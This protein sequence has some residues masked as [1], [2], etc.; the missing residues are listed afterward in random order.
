MP[1]PDVSFERARLD[2]AQSCL[3]AMRAR[4]A[5]KVANDDILAANEADTEAVRWHLQRRLA[6][7]DDDAA[8]LCFGRIDEETGEVWYVGRRHI[9]DGDAT[10]VVVDWRAGVATPFYRATLADPFGLRGRRRFVFNGRDL[11]DVFEEDFTDPDSL[12]GSGGVPDPLL[13]E[14]GRARTGQMRDIV[15]TIQAEQD[16]IIRAPIETCLVVQGGP[17]TGKTAVGLHRAAFLM[18]EHRDRLVR[19]GVLV[20]GPNPVFLRYISQVLPSLGE[21]S[22]TQTTVD[23]LLSLRFRIVAEDP[24]AV[25]AVKGDARLAEVIAHGAADAIRIPDEGVTVRFRTR[26]FTLAPDDVRALVADARRR[27]APFATQR[28]RFRQ[29]LVRRA[30]DRYTGGVAIE[31]DEHDFGVALLA[32]AQSRKAIDGCWRSVSPVAL[33]R[34]LLTQRG[35]L[36]RAADGVLDDEEQHAILRRKPKSG[37]A[38]TADDLPLIDEAEAFVK[39]GGRRYGHVVVDEAQDLSPMQLRMIAR[40]AHRHSMTVLGDLAQATGPASPAT[41]EAT[42]EHLGRPANAQPAELTMGYRLPGAFLALANRLL[43]TAAPGVAAS[44][45]VRADGDPPDVHAL[46]PEELVSTIAEHALA[47]A[48][49]FGTVAVIAA[50]GRVEAL[51]RAIEDRGVVLAEPGEVSPDRPLVVL[52]ARLAK[53]LEFDAVIV[54]EPAEIAALE[55]HGVRLLFVALTRAVQHLAL[56]HALPLP[57]VLDDPD[58]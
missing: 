31:L 47:L 13:A 23:G 36:A 18:Y 24:L 16:A 2:F 42:L 11:A 10:P 5:A 29:S 15:A 44:R 17:G 6:S 33:V 35:L 14:L 43:A 30:Y 58:A 34:S 55:P 4:T 49:E 9:E 19:E 39:G 8:A 26:E 40:R 54:A 41:W 32:D 25:A 51:R 7:F 48:K 56:A 52:S 28:E 45:S 38:W 27:D 3:E 37:D 57:E 20:V 1:H 21:T 53:G 50:D 12:A 22:A 46:D